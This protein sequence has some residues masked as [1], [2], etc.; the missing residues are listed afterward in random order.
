MDQHKRQT[1]PTNITN[2]VDVTALF[3]TIDAVKSDE[4]LADFHFRAS[5]RWIDGG[6]NRSTIKGF[7]GCRKEDELRKQA[8]I[9]DADERK[10]PITPI[11][12]MH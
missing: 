4:Q 8:F 10:R 2:G 6:H 7:Y 1:E 5:N 9:L 11:Y 12:S 3:N